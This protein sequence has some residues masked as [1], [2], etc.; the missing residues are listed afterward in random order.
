MIVQRVQKIE[1][2]IRNSLSPQ[3]SAALAFDKAI[4]GTVH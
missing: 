3:L 1:G 4:A 2:T